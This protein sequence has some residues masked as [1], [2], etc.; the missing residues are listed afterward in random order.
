MEVGRL[1]TFVW[2]HSAN[3]GGITCAL[4][5]GGCL[6]PI[7]GFV[8]Q[9]PLGIKALDFSPGC[10]LFHVIWGNCAFNFFHDLGNK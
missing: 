10:H 5:Q 6:H 1:M 4:H 8:E 7:F 9:H 3:L 2:F